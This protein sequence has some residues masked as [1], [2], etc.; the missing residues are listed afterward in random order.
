MKNNLVKDVNAFAELEKELKL[1]DRQYDGIPYWDAIRFAVCESVFTT[2]YDSS[3]TDRIKHN[4]IIIRLKSLFW[5]CKSFIEYM[6]L[7]HKDILFFS[8]S[9]L[10]SRFFKYLILPQEVS[11]AQLKTIWQ[12]PKISD[13]FLIPSSILNIYNKLNKRAIPVDSTEKEFLK[14]LEKILYDKFGQS[15]SHVQME[16]KIIN[17]L[18]IRETYIK[19]FDYI[20]KKTKCRLI[21]LTCYYHSIYYYLIEAAHNLGIPVVELQHG[22]A[23]NHIAYTFEDRTRTYEHLPDYFFTFGEIHS[24]WVRLPESIKVI[25]TGNAYQEN[26]IKEFENIIPDEKLIIVYPKLSEVFETMI[27]EL[28]DSITTKGYKVIVKMHPGESE[29]YKEYYPIIAANTNLTIE[30]GKDKSIYYW[31]HSACHHVMASSTVGMEALVYD[32][33]NI[34]IAENVEHAQVQCL[35]DADVACGFKSA[36]E[37][38]SLIINSDKKHEGFNRENFWKSNATNNIKNEIQRILSCKDN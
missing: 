6:F 36:K 29:N 30:T 8:M 35:L 15:M 37:L 31:L 2:R 4:K 1:F 34:Y 23:N 18:K 21:V 25:A 22:V 10:H 24:S 11:S 16:R 19:F 9:R 27:C 28:A 14:Q 17:Y 32:H 20:I 3:K 5:G 13:L 33:T 7:G 12:D 26:I 38:E